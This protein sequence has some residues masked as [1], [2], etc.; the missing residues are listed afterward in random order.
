MAAE[1]EDAPIADATAQ[2]RE[3]KEEE[4]AFVNSALM[5]DSDEKHS[6]NSSST[7]I[8]TTTKNI[9]K[10]TTTTTAVQAAISSIHHC[11]KASPAF[12][13][14]L[15]AIPGSSEKQIEVCC[16]ACGATVALFF[17][18]PSLA[19]TTTTKSTTKNDEAAAAQLDSWGMCMAVKLFQDAQGKILLAVGYEGGHVVIWSIPVEKERN[20]NFL[21][22][23]ALGK[24]HS[25]PIMA[26]EIDG[27]GTT[28]VSGSAE[29]KLIAFTIDYSSGVVAALSSIDV[30]KEGV[31]DVAVRGDGK[32][33]AS[34]GWD[35]K[36][37]VYKR[38]TGKA[39]AV[40][41]YHS[42]AASAVAFSPQT[43]VLA[44]GARD[45]TVA[46]WDVYATP[47]NL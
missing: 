11:T 7:T 2:Q 10:C 15:L 46:L 25:E 28:G 29:D 47:N 34:A 14:A 1:S 4:E 41:K 23:L 8:G 37:R 18:D 42:Q 17:Q 3:K 22:P 26:L 19:S 16:T 24:L 12:P 40:L 43:H 27:L 39:L 9:K 5:P 38:A 33:L 36:V 6:E 31:A 21:K 20:R 30:R 35:G 44:S 32:L 13:A 45:G